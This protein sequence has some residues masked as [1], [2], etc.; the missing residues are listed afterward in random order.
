METWTRADG[1]FYH[2]TLSRDLFG[3]VVLVAHGGLT[4]ARVISIP[5]DRIE[6]GE[7]VMERLARRRTA[8]G[9]RR[10]STVWQGRRPE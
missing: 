2:I 10:V 6:D 7:R 9:Y 4:P 1:R 3:P 8:H 5:V